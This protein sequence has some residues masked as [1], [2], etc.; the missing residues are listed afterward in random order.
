ALAA[1]FSRPTLAADNV[2]SGGIAYTHPVEK[3]IDGLDLDNQFG[4]ALDYRYFITKEW[5][6]GVSA[7][8]LGSARLLPVR[9]NGQYY[10]DAGSGIHP[11][12]GA[13]F[14]YT[15]IQDVK[16]DNATI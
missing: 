6:I 9:L 13:G 4:A 12:L 8:E 14:N 5:A 2:I 10:F 16:F 3:G 7:T 1:V 15:Y 11:F